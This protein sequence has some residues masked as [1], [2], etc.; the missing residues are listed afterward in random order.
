[1][2]NRLILIVFTFLCLLSGEITFAQDYNGGNGGTNF[3]DPNYMWN[4]GWLQNVC[5][6]SGCNQL[7]NVNVTNDYHYLRSILEQWEIYTI[8]PSS[9]GG[10]AGDVE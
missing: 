2:K 4:L 3:D 5:V 8:E 6:G 10:A 1:M 7:D 9:G